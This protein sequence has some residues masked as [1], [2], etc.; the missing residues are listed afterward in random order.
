MN[1]INKTADNQTTRFLIIHPPYYQLLCDLT[2]LTFTYLPTLKQKK[3]NKLL[4][5][6]VFAVMLSPKAK[7]LAS[8]GNR[9]ILAGA[10]FFASLRFTQNDR[11]LYLNCE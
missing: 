7:H 10:R 4:K 9:A 11:L 6:S 8:A 2:Q 1:P 5:L 3:L